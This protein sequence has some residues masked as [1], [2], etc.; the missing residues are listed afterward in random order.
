M[1]GDKWGYCCKCFRSLRFY[2]K[3]VTNIYGVI[4]IL[5]MFC[6]KY[7]KAFKGS[8]SVIEKNENL[9]DVFVIYPNF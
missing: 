1:A 5:K 8:L 4:V 7:Q 9:N 3:N 2:S 6:V